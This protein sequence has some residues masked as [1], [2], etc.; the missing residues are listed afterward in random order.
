MFCCQSRGG[1]FCFQSGSRKVDQSTQGAG[2][3]SGLGSRWAGVAATVAAAEGNRT[4]PVDV[5]LHLRAVS[6]VSGPSV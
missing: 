5:P 6:C 1:S 3:L 4:R 2:Y